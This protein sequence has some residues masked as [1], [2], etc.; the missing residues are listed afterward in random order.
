MKKKIATATLALSLG[1][2]G[3]LCTPQVK[4]ETPQANAELKDSP[5]INKTKAFEQTQKFHEG[6]TPIQTYVDEKTG[7]VVKVYESNTSEFSTLGA[8]QWDH[9]GT[10]QWYMNG[11]FNSRQQDAIFSSGGG[12][13]MVRLPSHGLGTVNGSGPWIRIELWEDDGTYGDDYVAAFEGHSNNFQSYDYVFEN[14]GGAVDGS[15]A[16]FYTIHQANY[17]VPRPLLA[18]YYD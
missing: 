14:I 7:V 5:P 12:D 18:K 1:L 17:T 16:E 3:F 10:D 4:A 9:V 13:Y 8:G 11:N 6:E 15:H 2:T